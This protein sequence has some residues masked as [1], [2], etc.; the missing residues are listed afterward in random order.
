[1]VILSRRIECLSTL[2]RQSDIRV[3]LRKTEEVA[4]NLS[5]LRALPFPIPHGFEEGKTSKYPNLAPCAY[6]NPEK[7][8]RST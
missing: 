7:I 1:M 6:N 2:E 3:T 8:L 4:W 5:E